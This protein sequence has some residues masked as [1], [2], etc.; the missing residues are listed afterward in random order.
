[1]K[2]VIF[3]PAFA[4]ILHTFST[5]FQFVMASELCKLNREFIAE[6]ISA[7]HFYSYLLK[8]KSK[9]YHGKQKRDT[10]LSLLVEKYRLIDPTVDWKRV[11]KR[12]NTLRTNYRRENKKVGESRRSGSGTNDIYEQS[13]WYFH[14]FLFLDDQDSAK[15]LLI[16]L[17]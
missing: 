14:L 6:F 2:V 4:F 10:A 8:V 16:T 12:L 17:G 5:F 9:V 3:R 1:M 7:Y 15:T 13:L 11:S